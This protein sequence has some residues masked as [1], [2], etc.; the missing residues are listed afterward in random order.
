MGMQRGPYPGASST[1]GAVTDPQA[2]FKQPAAEAAAAE[3]QSG[4]AVGLGTGSTAIFA[5]RHI[6]ALLQRGELRDVVG[7]ATSEAT[8]R[9]AERLGIPMLAEELPRSL[10]LTIDGADEVD[11][12][13]NLIKGGGGAHVRE[14]IV[15]EA[16]A[17][18]VI[19]VDETKL[20]PRL[21]THHALPVEVL[22]FGWASQARY[23]DGLGG[24]ATV[25]TGPGGGWFRTDQGN[26][27][28]DCAFGPIGD[29]SALA[30]ELGGRAGIVGHGLF[31]G[32]ASAVV[33]ASDSGVR[34]LTPP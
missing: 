30:A 8:R 16:S 4:M 33:V 31:L 34:W 27:I 1:V 20:S 12:Q 3:V 7:F 13:L 26:L 19:V 32:L 23:L 14:K 24:T 6:G 17:R 15:A 10:D 11:P 21:G 9:E 2:G 25:R 18:E 5:T 29:P 22:E 28:L